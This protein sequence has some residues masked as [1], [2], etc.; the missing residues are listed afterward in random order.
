MGA[1]FFYVVSRATKSPYPGDL[2]YGMAGLSYVLALQGLGVPTQWLG[3]S[4]L[5]L[6]AAYIPV[7]KYVSRFLQKPTI[8][9]GV[10][11]AIALT[12]YASLQGFAWDQLLQSAIALLA[13][14]GFYVV[15]AARTK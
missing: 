2:V 6:V 10:A 11:S 15:I 5:A 12:I 13:V 9:T 3:I 7:Q 14:G 1:G 8:F 4:C